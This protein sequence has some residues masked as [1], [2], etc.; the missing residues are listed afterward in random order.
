MKR[1]LAIVLMVAAGLAAGAVLAAGKA[2]E[3]DK[4]K[5]AQA[6]AESWLKLVD[7]GKYAESW[8]QAAAFFKKAVTKDQWTQQIKNVREPMGKLASRAFKNATYTTTAPGAPDG[9]YVIIQFDASLANKKA[10]VETVTPMLD[11]DGQW[12]VS[13]YYIK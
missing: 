9:Q 8:D 11:P 3:A 7:E 6:A 13:G 2:S 4:K 12:R 5:A 10:A 1:N